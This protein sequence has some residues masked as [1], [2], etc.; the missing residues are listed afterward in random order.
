[1]GVWQKV[2]RLTGFPVSR[3]QLRTAVMDYLRRRRCFGAGAVRDTGLTVDSSTAVRPVVSKVAPSGMR[4]VAE[5][6]VPAVPV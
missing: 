2:K 4:V 5:D 3:L 6:F 1:M